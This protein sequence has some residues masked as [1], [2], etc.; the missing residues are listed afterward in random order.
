MLLSFISPQVH[1]CNVASLFIGMVLVD[2][3]GWPEP[4]N[5]VVAI[6]G[7]E[8]LGPGSPGWAAQPSPAAPG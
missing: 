3:V 5:L 4:W 2:F 6:T 7:R 8:E 1:V